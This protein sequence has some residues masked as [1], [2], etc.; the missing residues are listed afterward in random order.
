MKDR[1][2]ICRI[3]HYDIAAKSRNTSNLISHLHHKHSITYSASNL[4]MP[5][6]WFLLMVNKIQCKKGII[7]AVS[8]KLYTDVYTLSR[9]YSISIHKIGFVVGGEVPSVASV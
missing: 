9:F 3:C 4:V 1:K 5:L 8:M 6:L 7:Y 2:V